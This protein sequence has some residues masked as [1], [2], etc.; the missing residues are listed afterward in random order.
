MRQGPLPTRFLPRHFSAAYASTCQIYGNVIFAARTSW[1]SSSNIATYPSTPS[2]NSYF[3]CG[4][5]SENRRLT[6]QQLFPIAEGWSRYETTPRAGRRL[7][8]TAE[9]RST[10]RSETALRG[11]VG[12]RRIND[13]FCASIRS[14]RG[15]LPAPRTNANDGPAKRE[16]SA[17]PSKHSSRE[18]AGVS[19]RDFAFCS[20]AQM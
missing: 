11:R 5:R 2:G 9:R 12:C 6:I 7:H 18:H 16:H 1:P 15:Q 19:G 17:G 14:P 4:R 10:A 3:R 8:R 13:K 20:G